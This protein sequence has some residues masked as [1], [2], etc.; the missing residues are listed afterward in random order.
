MAGKYYAAGVGSV[1]SGRKRRRS[2][3]AG[4][5]GRV[6]VAAGA[7][8]LIYSCSRVSSAVLRSRCSAVVCRG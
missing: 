1:G 4:A 8:S 6:S 5:T 2:G 7:S 3:A